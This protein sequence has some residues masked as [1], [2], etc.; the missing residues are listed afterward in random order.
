VGKS[1]QSYL[2]GLESTAGVVAESRQSAIWES[3]AEEKNHAIQRQT[4]RRLFMKKTIA[5]AVM[6][7]GSV[8]G[9]GLGGE[10][11][12]VL[13]P[14]HVNY[15]INVPTNVRETGRLA[16]FIC[17]YLTCRGNNISRWKKAKILNRFPTLIG[18]K[19]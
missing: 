4:D 2:R 16:E 11:A 8:I 7:V 18:N 17:A 13:L 1:L 6:L 15:S 9:G 14:R 19:E 5:L 12:G 10:L 3:S